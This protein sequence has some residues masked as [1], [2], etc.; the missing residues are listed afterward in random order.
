MSHRKAAPKP[1]YSDRPSSRRFET[2][3]L[4]RHPG[5]ACPHGELDL[6]DLKLRPCLGHC[7]RPILTDRAH[8]VCGDCT[9]HN[10]STP[11][12]RTRGHG[13]SFRSDRGFHAKG[14]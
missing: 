7:G 13:I 6:A 4:S 12:A 9:R 10:H 2:L 14:D 11:P 1:G 8:R 5:P 3:R